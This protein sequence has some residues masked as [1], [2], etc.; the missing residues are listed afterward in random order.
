MDRNDNYSTINAIYNATL[1]GS[2]LIYASGF[3]VV[4]TFLERWG[5]RETGDQLLRVKYFHVGFLCLLFPL[6]WVIPMFAIGSMLRARRKTNK[7]N[8]KQPSAWLT[9]LLSL[10]LSTPLCFL[11]IFAHA[12]YIRHHGWETA[13]LVLF[14]LIGL[15]FAADPIQ[16]FTAQQSLLVL[17]DPDPKPSR[18]VSIARLIIAILALVPAEYLFWKLGTDL[19]PELRETFRTSITAPAAWLYLLFNGLIAF[20]YWRGRKRLQQISGE[21]PTPET[22][23]EIRS[24]RVVT[25]CRIAGF[26]FL[27]VLSFS[28]GWYPFIPAARGG[29]SLLEAPTATIDVKLSSPMSASKKLFDEIQTETRPQFPAGVSVHARTGSVAVVEVTS[30]SLFVSRL[31]DN[32]GPACWAEGYLPRVYELPRSNVESIEYDVVS[33]LRTENAPQANVGSVRR[34]WRVIF[35]APHPFKYVCALGTPMNNSQAAMP[36]KPSIG[37]QP[38]HSQPAK[39]TTK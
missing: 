17:S 6:L 8:W 4:Y 33:S 19:Y 26:Y 36:P 12:D 7:F 31:D 13:S 15:I 10:T 32:G 27:G 3:I 39:A 11:P 35:G 2:A 23:S 34:A 9:P 37:P 1:A 18:K 29:G 5:I 24:V 28:Y 20:Y 38:L 22:Q 16:Q 25:A 14:A 30:D 21:P